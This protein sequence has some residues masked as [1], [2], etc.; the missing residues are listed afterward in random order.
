[1]TLQ[2]ESNEPEIQ[3]DLTLCLLVSSA[4]NLFKQFGSRSGPTFRRSWSGSKLFDTLIVF[5]KD[6]LIWCFTSQST[7]IDMPRH[8]VHLTTLFLGKL[9]YKA[10]SQYFMHILSLVTDKNL[11]SISGRRRMTVEIISRYISTKVWDRACNP[12]ICI[13]TCYQLCYGAGQ[14][15]PERIFIK[16]G[17]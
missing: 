2:P 4:D 7:A 11:S 6:F 5:L 17:F 3:F 13:Q 10:D 1:M 12:W 16:S 14:N 9:D 15:I 8:S